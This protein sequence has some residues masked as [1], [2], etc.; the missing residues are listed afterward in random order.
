MTK[1]AFDDEPRRGPIVR[2]PMSEGFRVA[3]K[4]VIAGHPADPR[5]R[6]R[7]D[8]R[9]PE[10]FKDLR[11]KPDLTGTYVERRGRF[12]LLLN[13]VGG[14]LECLLT[15][16][17]DANTYHSPKKSLD[18]DIRLPFDW[19]IAGYN[20]SV[21]RPSRRPPI[22]FR[23]S[24][25]FDKATQTYLLYVPVWLGD[26][27]MPIE[28][29]EVLP[30]LG[31]MEVRAD[32]EELDITFV[33][34]FVQSWPEVEA[35]F[36]GEDLSRD[37]T[38]RAIRDDGQPALL[39]R[40]LG[41]S[42]VPYEAR[43]HYWFG[44]TPTQRE[45][46]VPLARELYRIRVRV[47][48]DREFLPSQSDEGTLVTLYDL[49]ME[50]RTLGVGA[51]VSVRRA[52][53]VQSVDNIIKELVSIA[54]STPVRG[55]G[56]R[57]DEEE[58]L[59]VQVLRLLDGWRLEATDEHPERSIAVVLQDTLDRNSG[60]ENTRTI[61]SFLKIK[62]GGWRK[63]RYEVKVTLFQMF[64]FEEDATK[65]AYKEAKKVLKKVLKSLAGKANGIIGK[66]SKYLPVSHI[67]GHM[68]VRFVG[69]VEGADDD[70]DIGTWTAEYGIAMAGAK[71][72]KSA[73]K[74]GASFKLEGAAELWGSRPARP[75]DLD[76][77]A[78]YAEGAAVAAID[79]GLSDGKFSQKIGDGKS[80]LTL[81]GDFS[82]QAIGFVFEDSIGAKSRGGGISIRAL[83]GTAWLL[84]SKDQGIY[85]EPK[86][87]TEEGSFHDYWQDRV[88]SLAVHFPI[89]GAR[90]GVP[91]REEL[92]RMH[93]RRQLSVKEALNAFAASELPLIANP[94]ATITLDGFADA[95]GRVEDNEV[96][97]LNRAKSVYQYLDSI[98]GSHFSIGMDMDEAIDLGRASINGKGEPERRGGEKV[99]PREKEEFDPAER[100]VDVAVGTKVGNG[101]S[102]SLKWNAARGHP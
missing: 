82:E 69:V 52:N 60:R 26:V 96:L 43:T 76:G 58:H 94:L 92:E 41:R 71:F 66:A 72:S 44:L 85:L 99:D 49:M 83:T 42:S 75:E 1:E 57:G 35:S 30:D 64:D 54:F 24:A 87:R 59:R 55:G 68:E 34:A 100:R 56:I 7:N 32:G 27:V 5:Q 67:L 73:G 8:R 31:F 9:T 10:P 78:T 89:N 51:G 36:S 3:G 65:D 101:A 16:V 86:D 37:L 18:E 14:H 28:K 97:S 29:M 81:F 19:G 13:H 46:I 4:E 39:E 2:Q 25:D 93:E 70:A 80:L 53:I 74:G 45:N 84:D 88:P 23:F 17:V 90:L 12:R 15:L 62:P 6:V 98:M 77:I 50:A 48:K 33:P 63:F 102:Q 95:P 38:T 47:F 61:E 20:T 91:T 79:S 40:Y 22:T 11:I 21:L